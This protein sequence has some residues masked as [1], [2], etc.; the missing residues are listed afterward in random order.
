MAAGVALAAV[1]V[2]RLLDLGFREALNRPFDPMVDWGYAGS[3]VETVR[4]SAPGWLGVALLVGAGVP[5]WPRSCCSPS[6]YAGSLASRRATGRRRRASSPCSSRV[7]W[8]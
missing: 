7:G 2:L 6:P 4:G 1:A 5:S 8:C 3:L